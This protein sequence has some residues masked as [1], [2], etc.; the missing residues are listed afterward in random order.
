M[1]VGLLCIILPG[2]CT[3]AYFLRVR[4]KNQ[5]IHLKT[6]IY[7]SYNERPD[8]A[9][10]LESYE[11]QRPGAGW[12]QAGRPRNFSCLYGTGDGGQNLTPVTGEF[13]GKGIYIQTSTH[14]SV[15]IC[16]SLMERYIN[17]LTQHQA[18]IVGA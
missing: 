16:V 4:E 15:R 3:F 5:I 12:G 13:G 18:P 2:L 14:R 17:D 10:E 6:E 7:N 8:R 11:S 1:E 9:A